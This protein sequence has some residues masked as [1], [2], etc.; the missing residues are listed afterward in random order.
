VLRGAAPFRDSTFLPPERAERAQKFLHILKEA[1]DPH[2]Q[3]RDNRSSNYEDLFS[4]AQQMLDDETLEVINPLLGPAI[5]RLRRTSAFLHVGE[6]STVGESSF[7]TLVRDAGQ[8]IQA[9]VSLSLSSSHTIPVIG[10]E[11]INAVAKTVERVD[12]FTLNHDVLLERQLQAANIR[13]ADGFDVSPKD[14]Y[15]VFKNEWDIPD[16]SIRLL[17]L[18]GSINWWRYSENG[19]DRFY[20]VIGDPNYL[21]VDGLSRKVV[22][23]AS[24]TPEFLTGTTVKERAYGIGLSRQILGRFDEFLAEHDTLICC[25]YGWGDKGINIR[26]A[27]WMSDNHDR[28][29]VILH[30]AGDPG[31]HPKEARFWWR[32][33]NPRLCDH[34][35]VS[36]VSKWLGACL[37][38]D[39]MPFFDERV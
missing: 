4:A 24:M 29:V 37:V 26:V 31:K 20:S 22:A 10:L 16:C 14:G 35:Q 11:V 12:I 34:I 21:H 30:G 13:F 7:A 33:W 27:E 9:S 5:E 25:G 8:L 15:R 3:V 1:I 18:H 36:E 19:Q 6:D 17:K 32:R 23:P 39:L 28:R 2:L 38:D